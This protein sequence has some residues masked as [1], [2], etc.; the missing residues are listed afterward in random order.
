VW[1]PGE[2]HTVRNDLGVVA[3]PGRVRSRT[4]VLYFSQHT[5]AHICDAQSPSRLEVGEHLAWLAPG[6]D[7]GHRPQEHATVHVLDQMVR[8]T[9]AVRSS[10]VSGAPMAFCIQ[11]GDNTDNRQY[12]ELRWFIDTLDGRVITPN[13]GSSRY[14]GAQ[15]MSEFGWVYHPEDPSK[16][17]YG[18]FGFP[19]VPGLLASSIQPFQAAGIAVPWLAVLGN[20]D[21]IFQGTFGNTGPIRLGDV[22]DRLAGS[23]SKL[24]RLGSLLALVAATSLEGGA[25]AERLER[26]ARRGSVPVTADTDLRRPLTLREQLDEYFITRSRPGPVGHG[27]TARNLA[28]GTAYWARPHV[29]RF[30][31][32]GLDTNNHTSG[33]EGRMGPRQRR[34]LVEQLDEAR[35]SDLLVIAFSHHNSWTMTNN[36]HDHHDP[37]RPT[38]GG[39]LVD[40]LRSRPEVI[41]WV[42]GHAHENRIECHR[43]PGRSSHGFWEVC[44]AS[45][46]DFGQQS[47]TFEILDNGDGTLSI[48]VTVLDHAAEP[49]VTVRPDGRYSSAELASFSREFAANDARWVDPWQQRGAPE[50]R[51]VELLVGGELTVGKPAGAVRVGAAP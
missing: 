29:D 2:G 31:L 19:C 25:T 28:H 10:P 33:S 16:D 37:G 42:N 9:N 14:E 49:S 26:L 30:L 15:G 46:V 11:T 39:E 4:S 22:G 50:D 21:M 41:L 13:T 47:R 48:L 43:A 38:D 40:L 1:G 32:L 45:C 34:W 8:A 51:N 5:D 3:D 12:A 27:F 20:H 17:P 23:G 44:T 6:T 35:R 18:R 7:A 24:S 36:S